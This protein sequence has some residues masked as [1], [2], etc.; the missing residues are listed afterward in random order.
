MSHYNQNKRLLHY[1]HIHGSI[2]RVEAFIE[3]GITELSSR[4]NEINSE[5]V[6][7]I[8]SWEQSVNKY[9]E[10]IRYKRYYLREDIEP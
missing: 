8:S 1:L 2:T 7:I 5:G 3:L 6:K 9:D 10:K 4:V